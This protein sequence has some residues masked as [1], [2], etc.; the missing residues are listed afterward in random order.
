M[1]ALLG[2][3][4]AAALYVGGDALI[5][6]RKAK[7]T[8]AECTTIQTV[9]L[10]TPSKRLWLRKYVK[11]DNADGATRIRTALRVAGVLA[12]SNPVD[13][14]QVNVLDAHG[15]QKRADMRGRTI[16][17]EVIIALQP[18]YLPEMSTPLTARYYDGLPTTDGR[19]YG[20]RVDLALGDIKD[21][22]TAMKDSPDKEG[23]IEPERPDFANGQ[24]T[25]KGGDQIV[26]VAGEHSAAASPEGQEAP[27]DVAKTADH[28]EKTAEQPSFLDS[29]LGFVGLGTAPKPEAVGEAATSGD[30]SAAA[31]Q[32]VSDIAKPAAH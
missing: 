27:V 5:G 2:G 6:P 18:K 16:G 8:G 15:P 10:K 17:A 30:A 11:M 25:L 12:K 19:F 23:C 14:I 9:V 31:A 3:S 29:V 22:M 20:E 32:E 21:L 7:A 4:G 1:L 13:L 26:S 28:G 24:G